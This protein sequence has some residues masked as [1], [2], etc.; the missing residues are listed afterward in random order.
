MAKITITVEKADLNFVMEWAALGLLHAENSPPDISTD[1]YKR[2][3]SAIMAGI[4]RSKCH[5]CKAVLEY[6]EAACCDSCGKYFCEKHIK[7]G[8]ECDLCD[9]CREAEHE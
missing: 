3:E 7:F 5:R 1:I 9:K 2:V 6:G 8:E 4:A